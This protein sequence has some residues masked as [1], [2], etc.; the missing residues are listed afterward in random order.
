MCVNPDSKRECI[1]G[2]D[3]GIWVIVQGCAQWVHKCANACCLSEKQW[4]V[5]LQ[6]KKFISSSALISSVHD[7]LS[8]YLSLI[9]LPKCEFM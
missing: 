6:K 8:E 2:L 7:C 5:F 3:C 4:F 9:S 1:M